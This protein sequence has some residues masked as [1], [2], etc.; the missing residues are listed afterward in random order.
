MATPL[1]FQVTRNR[2]YL[3]TLGP[4]VGIGHGLKTP[5]LAGAHVD[6][7]LGKGIIDN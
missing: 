1:E 5:A 6:L 2:E 7:D 3:Q 4:N